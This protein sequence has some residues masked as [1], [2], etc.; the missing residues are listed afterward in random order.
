M[1]KETRKVIDLPDRRS[2]ELE[3]ANFV[4]RRGSEDFSDDDRR[5]LSA[6]LSL[7]E[8]HRQAYRSLAVAWED[9][10]VLEELNDIADSVDETELIRGGYRWPW[11]GRG[12]VAA[13]ACV[14]TA[15]IFMLPVL[16]WTEWEIDGSA[17][18]VTDVGQQRNIDLPDGSLLHLNTSTAVSVTLTSEARHVHLM[19]G[20]IFVE[21]A[22]DPDRPFI[23]NTSAGS[24]RALGTAFATRLKDRQRLEVTVTEG[25]VE[26]APP[27]TSIDG[28]A[29]RGAKAAPVEVSA[30]AMAVYSGKETSIEP[31]S[32]SDVTRRL[33]WRDGVVVFAGEPLKSV[34]EDVSRYTELDIRI[35]DDS[36]YNLLIGG[37]FRI[38]DVDPLLESLEIAFG[39][40]VERTT[41]GAILLKSG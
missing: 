14:I 15:V 4:V 22:H 37:Y 33:S 40:K 36:L 41:D 23:V 5:R 2:I 12:A 9:A 28:S 24:V 7:S 1:K 18:Y 8:R 25:R 29:R 20:E 16:Q 6:W 13:V 34:I 11:L 35:V 38:G 27:N 39:I 10:A 26:M 30:G 19:Q 31:V 3:A 32:P 17:D 21:V